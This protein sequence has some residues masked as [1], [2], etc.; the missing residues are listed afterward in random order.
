M[1]FCLSLFNVIYILSEFYICRKFGHMKIIVLPHTQ[2]E[3]GKLRHK[4]DAAINNKIHLD[5]FREKITIMSWVKVSLVA[6]KK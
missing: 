2:S 1:H 4:N 6:I 3:F 5:Q